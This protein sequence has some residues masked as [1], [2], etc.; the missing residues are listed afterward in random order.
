[1]PGAHNK[2]D[3]AARERRHRN[4]PGSNPAGS[5]A[6]PSGN[7]PEPYD[8]PGSNAGESRGRS[9]SVAVTRTSSRPGSQVR[10]SSQARQAVDPARDPAPQVLLRNV[11]FGGAAYNIFS[12]VSLK[13]V[14]VAR[15]PCHPIILIH[16]FIVCLCVC[17]FVDS[18][19]MC[20]YVCVLR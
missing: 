3:A 19:F 5:N 14:L 6:G 4:Q 8:G 11:D 16:I 9:G 18:V 17:L 13:F 7:Q 20:L 15:P 2:R 10:G 1:M 12:Q